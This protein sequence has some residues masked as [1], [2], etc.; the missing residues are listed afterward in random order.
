MAIEY[1]AA[2]FRRY[3]KRAR[4]QYSLPSFGH[5]FETWLS[6]L[7]PA[8]VIANTLEKDY[9]GRE[10]MV[11]DYRDR[12][13]Q[14]L[15]PIRCRTGLKFSD[16]GTDL[17]FDGSDG[18][19]KT[20]LNVP[21]HIIGEAVLYELKR[22]R[23]DPET[24]EQLA[25][26]LSQHTEVARPV[27]DVAPGLK[28]ACRTGK[29]ESFDRSQLPDPGRSLNPN[30]A[31]QSRWLFYDHL[32]TLGIVWK[33]FM[34]SDPDAQAAFE[35]AAP[36]KDFPDEDTLRKKGRQWLKRLERY[37]LGVK[38]DPQS[39]E[40]SGRFQGRNYR[41]IPITLLRGLALL[42]A[43]V[44]DNIGRKLIRA[45]GRAVGRLWT[46]RTVTG[47]LNFP[48]VARAGQ[49]TLPGDHQADSEVETQNESG[50]SDTPS[51]MIDD[52]LSNLTGEREDEAERA[53][54]P[55]QPCDD[56]PD[57]FT[58]DDEAESGTEPETE[59]ETEYIGDPDEILK[60][61]LSEDYPDRVQ[62]QAKK[63]YQEEGSRMLSVLNTLYQLPW[64]T[65][66]TELPDHDGEE[67]RSFLDE[68]HYG[69]TG[70]KDR[71]VEQL[72]AWRHAPS[73]D[74]PNVCLL[75]PPGVGKSTI[76]RNI[77]RL[78]DRPFEM[79]SLAGISSEGGLQGD[80]RTYSG[81]TEGQISRAINRAGS[82]SPVMLLDELDKLGGFKH[83]PDAVL[84]ALL[85]PD[86]ND[87]FYE[88]FLRVTLDLSD[89]MFVVTANELSVPGSLENRLEIVRVSGYTTEDKV[90]IA[91]DYILP[92]L[93]ETYDVP[94]FELSDD[95][96]VRI[97]E[98]HTA[99]EEGVRKLRSRLKDLVRKHIAGFID[100]DPV[101]ALTRGQNSQI[102][103]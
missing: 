7:L 30:R 50:A 81:A 23:L 64:R 93:R 12:L 90:I 35:A 68:S 13:T 55:Q 58:D 5:H 47:A 51:D 48:I 91:R 4:T 100:D 52:T 46:G 53:T 38:K 28:P 18:W 43:Y 60:I 79:I 16:K 41:H 3:R 61:I 73:V 86:Q 32:A 59:T 9:E 65:R 33:D 75:G 8:R 95:Q 44:S 40:I 70:V 102:G 77:A 14:Y 36:H 54:P 85:D 11:V 97:I 37:G 25:R 99:G 24:K 92:E 71:I 31:L 76:A 1:D 2:F 56:S 45:I 20:E 62:K 69:L 10:E 87:D 82:F 78:L 17:R 49:L 22:G 84:N 21:S 27:Y 74:A 29:K 94:E 89:V 98:Q 88:R 39:D 26:G 101:Q 19:L 42:D 103:F 72:L 57:L 63:E 80:H 15:T 6:R 83:R 34:K 66:Q 67:A 96:I